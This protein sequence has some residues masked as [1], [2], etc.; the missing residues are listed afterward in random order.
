MVEDE[1]K[2]YSDLTL[3][4]TL[5][6][7]CIVPKNRNIQEVIGIL[8]VSDMVDRYNILIVN[9]DQIRCFKT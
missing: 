5:F 1:V 4:E 7:L 3:E 8:T 9:K 6:P 2:S